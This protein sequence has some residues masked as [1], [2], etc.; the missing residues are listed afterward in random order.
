[1]P[2]RESPLALW[3]QQSGA[4]M[5]E[6]AGWR[7]PLQYSSVAQEAQATRR[8]A[9]VFDISHMGNLRLI[10]P[11]AISAAR[12]LLT[13]D[14]AAVPVG[15]GA[16]ALLCNE[17]GGILDDLIFLVMSESEIALVVNAVNHDKDAAWLNGRA[18]RLG[19]S[20][21]HSGVQLKDLRGRSFGLALQGPQAEAVI[22]RTE[23]QGT[24]PELFATF[25]HMCLGEA[26]LLVSRTGYTGEDGFEIFGSASQAAEVWEALFSSGRDLG[27]IPAGLAARDVLRQEMGYPLWGQDIDEQ[28]TSLDAG[29]RWA[30]DWNRDFI[31]RAALE[32][33]QPTRRRLGFIMQDQ[34]IARP[35]AAISWGGKQIGTVTSGTYS[36]N[37]GA[38]IGQGY[39]SI[40]S[41]AASGDQVEIAVRGK[42]MMARLQK[43]PLIPKKTRRSWNQPDR[44]PEQ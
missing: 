35:G 9:G 3:H 20:G 42:A 14:A 44:R 31:G 2:L 24:P 16:Y 29:L 4:R 40:S 37:L 1:M 8:A 27:L 11:G 36:H 10:G 19:D 39:I 38:A 18:S 25:S 23:M 34:G 17:A 12:E 6:F 33:A 30:I 41:Q 15:C 28:T 13:R 7:L 26:G 21:A 5:V 22:R 43:L 32:N